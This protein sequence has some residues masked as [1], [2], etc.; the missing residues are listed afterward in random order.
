M[1]VEIDWDTLDNIT[2]KSLEAHY[3]LNKEILDDYYHNGAWL[4]RDDLEETSLMIHH[5][6]AVIEYYGGSVE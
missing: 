3:K 6:K 2:V 5:L 1:Q 4:H